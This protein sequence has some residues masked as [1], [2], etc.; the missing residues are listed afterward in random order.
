MAYLETG[1]GGGKLGL[2]ETQCCGLNCVRQKDVGV[3]TQ[4]HELAQNV[5]L[6]GDRIFTRIVKL[7]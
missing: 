6:F 2:V 7:K 1:L 4:P 5:V 3:L